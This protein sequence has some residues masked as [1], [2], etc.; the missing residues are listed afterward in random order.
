MTEYCSIDLDERRKEPGDGR[1][2]FPHQQEAFKAMDKLFSFKVGEPK[3]AL[4]VLPTGAG[5]TF[6]S[7]NWIARKVFAKNIKVLW[8]AQSFHL[9]DQAFDSFASVVSQ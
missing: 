9:L 8:L 6:T 4:L 1:S 5:K 3:S 2:P 7:V